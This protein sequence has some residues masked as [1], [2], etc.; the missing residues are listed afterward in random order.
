[1]D[2][3]TGTWL[4][5]VVR[6]SGTVESTFHFTAEG[7]ARLI[8]VEGSA[9]LGSGEGS[10][11]GVWSATAPGGFSYRVAEPILDE[12]GVCLGWAHI[13]QDAVQD[14][15]TFTSTGVTVVRDADARLVREVAVR[16]SARRT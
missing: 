9:R 14:G 15:D 10:G 6:P 12:S 16:I 8:S 7:S 13:A 4:A 11:D 2:D 1:M 3:P 5:Q